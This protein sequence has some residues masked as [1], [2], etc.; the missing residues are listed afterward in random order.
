VTATGGAAAG[1]GC[2]VC[3]V[4]RYSFTGSGTTVTDSVGTSHGTARNTTLASGAVALAGTTSDQYV[5]LPASVFSGLTNATFEAW[6]TW[7]AGA[8]WQR[9]F[10]F[11][12]N[13]GT[14]A[15][16][17]GPNGLTYFFLSPKAVNNTGVL[18]VAYTL[19]GPDAE[20]TVDATA[21]LPSGVL[22]HVAVVVDSAAST[23]A[24][25]VNGAASGSTALSSPLSSI[26][27]ENNWLGR[28]QFASDPEFGGSLQEFRVYSV[29][30]SAAQVQ[31]SYTAGPD[32]LPA[33]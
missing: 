24:L 14:A 27:N 26:N 23:L 33:N 22:A 1:G 12:D 10:D 17:Q 18:R 20:T 25:Y 5:Q 9:I 2:G 31:A 29:A 8:A 3:V 28:S 6:V 16:S 13:D 32:A 15:G 11:G 7:N 4:H 30:R 19:D 21:A